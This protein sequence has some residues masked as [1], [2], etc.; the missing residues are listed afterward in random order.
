MYI[1]IF[2]Y[3]LHITRSEARY[4]KMSLRNQFLHEW[5]CFHSY[6]LPDFSCVC[7]RVRACIR[8]YMCVSVSN[9]VII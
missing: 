8:V 9:T 6:G 7:T 4:L 3:C 5:L 1:L 2:I